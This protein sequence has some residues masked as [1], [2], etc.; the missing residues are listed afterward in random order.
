MTSDASQSPREV[1]LLPIGTLIVW[2]ICLTIGVLGVWLSY[3]MPLAPARESP[4]VQAQLIDVMAGAPAAA[5]DVVPPPQPTPTD[6]PALPTSPPPPEET[7]VEE[8]SPHIAFAVPAPAPAPAANSSANASSSK[9]GPR[10]QDLVLGVGEGQ[11]PKP[12]Y[13]L[14]AMLAHEQGTVVVEFTVDPDGNVGAV[15]AKL[16]TPYFLLNEAA[17]RKIRDAW[18]FP[19]GPPRRF[20]VRITFQLREQ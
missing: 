7:A 3:P 19:P 12:D 2:L 11:Q 6:A 15:R 16:P 18:R 20:D 8:P 14:E 17:V 13:P 9:A 4:P 10:V 1:G 5:P